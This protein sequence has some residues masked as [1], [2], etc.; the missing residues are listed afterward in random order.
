MGQYDLCI[1]S[2]KFSQDAIIQIIKGGRC[3]E[4]AKWGNAHSPHLFL[5]RDIF[6]QEF[7]DLVFGW[8]TALCV[9]FEVSG[10]VTDAG[11][12]CLSSISTADTDFFFVKF[13][14]ESSCFSISSAGMR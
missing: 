8:W 14:E 3:E 9:V 1:D 6:F 7:V 2:S 13:F 5:F 12:A 4:I 10:A 11:F